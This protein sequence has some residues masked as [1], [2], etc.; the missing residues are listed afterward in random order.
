MVTIITV[1]G[2]SCSQPSFT[3]G[4][5][6]LLGMKCSLNKGTKIM[7]ENINNRQIEA[8]QIKDRCRKER[9]SFLLCS[10]PVSPLSY[11]ISVCCPNDSSSPVLLCDIWWSFSFFIWKPLV[12]VLNWW[13][14]SLNQ[15]YV[16][17]SFWTAV[18]FSFPAA[19]CS[20]LSWQG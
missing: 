16:T 8:K 19:L 17:E 10:H 18:P 12:F 7:W 11:G 5:P 20:C 6:C 15:P 4:A 13:I 2:S 14:H 9:D 1:T 3:P